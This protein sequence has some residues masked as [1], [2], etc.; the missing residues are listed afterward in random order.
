MN[1]LLERGIRKA[2]RV[3]KYF[4]PMPDYACTP[5]MPKTLVAGFIHRIPC[6]LHSATAADIAER[7][8]L[9][10]RLRWIGKDGLLFYGGQAPILRGDRSQTSTRVIVAARAPDRPED[11]ALSVSLVRGRR[12]KILAQSGAEWS[13]L[14]LKESNGFYHYGEYMIGL[15]ASTRCNLECIFCLREFMEHLPPAEVTREEMEQLAQQAFDG[16]SGLSLSLGAEPLLNT[17]LEKIVDLLGRYPYLFTTMTSNGTTLG[18]KLA[19]LLVTRGYKEISV[20]IDGATK[21]TYESIR[22]GAR[23]EQLIRNLKRLQ[24]IK[25]EVGSPYPRLK[26]H[27]AMMRRNIHELPAFVEMARELGAE[28]IRFQYFMIPHESLTDEC[29]WFDPETTNRFLSE[30]RRKCEE[31]GIRID[32]PPLFDLTRQA[33]SQKQLRTQ[34]CRWP[35]KGMLLGPQGEAYPCCQWK[36]PILGNVKEQGFETVWNG[37]AY[38][39]LRRDWISGELNE[40]CRNCSALM[41]GD[42]NDFSSFIAAEYEL[43]NQKKPPVHTRPALQ[44]ET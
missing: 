32:A 38:R 42:V 2:K 24:A 39:Q 19:R 13:I 15:D 25:R 18:E 28:E 35:W 33:G 36:G 5:P 41:E 23:F 8:E 34:Q 37:E 12:E 21:E 27:F 14:P 11:Y 26:F 44:E 29:L 17:Q 9:A 30:A 31:Y 10:V 6:D 7:D 22:K 20:S 40:H 1:T 3:V 43:I 16:C 4:T